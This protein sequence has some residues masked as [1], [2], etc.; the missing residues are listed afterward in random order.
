MRTLVELPDDLYQKLRDIAAR[1]EWSLQ[2][3]VRQ[4]MEAYAATTPLPPE[5]PTRWIFPTLEPREMVP[6]MERVRNETTAIE[7]RQ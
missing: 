7:E 2:E 6:G 1:R 3:V 4:G 5:E